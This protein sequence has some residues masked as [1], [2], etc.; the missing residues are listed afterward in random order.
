MNEMKMYLRNIKKTQ[1]QYSLT[2]LVTIYILP[3]FII[4]E[5]LPYL[6]YYV[7]HIHM[8]ITYIYINM[9]MQ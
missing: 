6:S 9:M 1:F 5:Q 7:Y 3:I 8:Y 2:G 4:W